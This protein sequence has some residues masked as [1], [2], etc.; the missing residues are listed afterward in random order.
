[1]AGLTAKDLAAEI[2][3]RYGTY[4]SYETAGKEPRY[5]TLKKIASALHVSIDDLLDYEPDKITT[6]GKYLSNGTDINL[7][8]EGEGVN[9]VIGKDGTTSIAAE[10][11]EKVFLQL[12]Q[13]AEREADKELARIKKRIICD[14]VKD[15]V[16]GQHAFQLV[17]K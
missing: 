14:I 13:M 2:G 8:R 6:W 10:Y 1:M 5:D 4:N 7:L 16:I 3:I 12:M 11:S 15:S 17:G 9:V